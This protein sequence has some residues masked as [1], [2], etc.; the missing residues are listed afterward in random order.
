[1]GAERLAALGAALGAALALGC[2]VPTTLDDVACPDEGTELSYESFGKHFLDAWCQGCHGGGVERRQGAPSAY[3][4]DTVD[5]VR[6]WRERIFVRS[7]A[8]NTSMPPG[9]NN[10]S[11]EERALLAEWLACGAP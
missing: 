9:P 1:M 10:P 5:E 8:D 2:V 3:T 11:A 6:R 7:A 4:F